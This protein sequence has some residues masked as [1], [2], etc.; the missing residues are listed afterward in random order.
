MAH[1]IAKLLLEK[2][3]TFLER[4]EAIKTALTLGM[5]LS[6]IE[7]YLDWK[8][9]LKGRR[10]PS[11]LKSKKEPNATKAG[12][13]TDPPHEATPPKS[14]PVEFVTPCATAPRKLP[15]P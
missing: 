4:S 9:S 5:P 14:A 6:E 12:D 1:E 10:R 11:E 15:S 2:A 8:E 3:G 7:A 13:K